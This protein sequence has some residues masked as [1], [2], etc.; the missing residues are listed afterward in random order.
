V[1]ERF[2]SEAIKADVGREV[3]TRDAEEKHRKR[4]AHSYKQMEAINRKK[5]EEKD[6]GLN[7]TQMCDSLE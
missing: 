5:R 3:D 7:R 1:C 2:I 4:Y 6:R